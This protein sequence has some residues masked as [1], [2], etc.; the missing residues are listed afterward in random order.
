M[1]RLHSVGVIVLTLVAVWLWLSSKIASKNLWLS[2]PILVVGVFG[3]YSLY[4]ILKS[5]LGLKD[6]P[7]E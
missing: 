4:S 7:D 3:V 1:R 6:Y 2:L 5:V